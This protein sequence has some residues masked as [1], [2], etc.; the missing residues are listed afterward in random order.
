MDTQ[1]G[2]EVYIYVFLTSALDGGERS[3]SRPGSFTSE[4]TDPGTHWIGVWMGPRA[5][6]DA[7]AKWK[8]LPYR[9]SNPGRP[10]RRSVNLQYYIQLT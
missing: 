6:V 3:A 7:V 8:Y 10:V 9:D 1:G 4:E 2:M 5:G